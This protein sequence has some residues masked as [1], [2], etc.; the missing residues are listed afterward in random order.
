MSR[1]NLQARFWVAAA[2]V[3]TLL[4]VAAPV[5]AQEKKSSGGSELS[6]L[7]MFFLSGDWVGIIITWFLILVSICGVSLIIYYTLQNRRSILAPP[8]TI[9]AVEQMLGER[10]FRDAIDYT[11]DDE[12]MFGQVIHASL[13]EAS[14]GFSAMERALEETS[15][16]LIARRTRSIEILSVFGAVGPMLGLFGTVYGMILAFWMLVQVTGQPNPADLA[17]GI[18]T[19][20]VTTFWGLVVGIPGVAAY[21]LIRNKIDAL[22]AEVTFEADRLIGQFRPKRSGASTASATAPPQPKPS[23]G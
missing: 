17:Q 14:N 23:G 3:I 9:E 5:M 10:K 16:M 4:A 22:S 2:A 19:A 20:L 21:A 6:Y 12:S 8:E 7:D 18:S 1:A 13:N 15:D 11:A